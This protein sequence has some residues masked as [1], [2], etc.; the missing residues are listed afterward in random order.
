[1]TEDTKPTNKDGH[2]IVGKILGQFQAV[3][4]GSFIYVFDPCRGEKGEYL[5]K[6]GTW[7]SKSPFKA[8][9]I[10]KRY[11]RMNKPETGK[12]APKIKLLAWKTKKL[13]KKN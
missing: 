6:L 2:E 7:V 3:E 12:L 10:A 1:M 8:N 9:K 5:L 13:L 11:Q 4:I